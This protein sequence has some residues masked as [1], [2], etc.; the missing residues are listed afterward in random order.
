[1]HD[2]QSNQPSGR[3]VY[4]RHLDLLL[5]EEFAC[6]PSF[7]TWVITQCSVPSDPEIPAGD[8]V[9]VVVDLSHDDDIGLDLG[10]SGENDLLVE[11]EWSNG[12]TLRLLVED[13]LDAVLQPTQ[14]ERYIARAE[15]HRGLDGVDHAIALIVAPADYLERHRNDLAGLRELSIDAIAKRF[16]E[17]ASDEPTEIAE[18]LRW[19]ADRL[20]SF[21]QRRRVSA[22]DHPPTVETRK[23]LLQRLAETEPRAVAFGNTLRTIKTGWLYFDEPS[24]I[25]YK[26]THGYVDVYLRD[27]WPEDPAKQAEAHAGSDLPDGFKPAEDTV[28]NLVLRAVVHDPMP[29]TNIWSNGAPTRESDLQ[30]GVEAC[31]AA[32]RWIDQMLDNQP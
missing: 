30:G 32:T 26:I 20:V 3:R 8:P 16:R 7:V 2:K 4:E 23:W 31:A 19:R 22:P 12:W 27:I 14:P 28:G 5:A 24:A 10:A 17:V 15:L 11:A 25:I 1:M 13:K 29:L 18:R 6:R 21:R 9:S